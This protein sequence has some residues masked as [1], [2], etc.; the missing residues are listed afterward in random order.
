MQENRLRWLGHV[1]RKE[2]TEAVSVAKN[3]SVDGKSGR[4]RPKKGGLKLQ[5]GLVRMTGVCEEDS[6]DCNK[7]KLMT[8]VA[9][10]K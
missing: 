4:G 5:S 8:R 6:K 7:W 3:M 9:D 2:K 1:L 10:P